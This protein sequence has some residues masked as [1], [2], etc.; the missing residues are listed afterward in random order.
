LTYEQAQAYIASL[1][2]RGWRLGLDRMQAFADRIGLQDALGAPGG[3]QFIHVA[4]TNG[5]GSVTAY[6]QSILVE[7]GYRTGAFFS[8]FVFDPRERVQLGREMISRDDLAALTE[9]LQPV[10]ESFS[11]TA[12]GGIT[13]FEFKT[14]LGFLYWKRKQCEWVALEVGLGGRLDATNV[15]TP[16][17]S[18]IVSIG[19]DH[20]SILG[21]TL[22]EIAYEKAG[23]IKPG[24]PVV[25]GKM[26]GEA[27]HVIE[28]VAEEQGSPVWAYGRE[29]HWYP[30]NEVHTPAGVHENLQ[31]GIPGEMQ[32]HNLALAV[33]AI[34]AV[35][36]RPDKRALE[37]G[38][39]FAFA[40]GRF[41][42]IE[43]RERRFLLD[44]A[45]NPDA[46]DVLVAGLR[47][48]LR[49]QQ[50]VLITN[51][52]AGHEPQSFYREI[53]ALVRSA[54]VVPID[55]HRALPV[56]DTAQALKT[57][58]PTQAHSSIAEGIDAAVKETADD[59]V[60]LVTG[61]FYL[62]GEVGRA[63]GVTGS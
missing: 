2:P 33:A 61:S 19:L 5:K 38:A 48:V 9:E 7:A 24:V 49:D 27:M 58:A 22:E 1:A 29:V 54:H 34:D 3:P 12:F 11:D 23:V 30:C 36:L 6:L 8:P 16:K 42:T 17:A 32:A 60:I 53:A 56:Q 13:E 37:S 59:D 10:A 21:N 28:R 47:D 41:Q 46:A 39:Q 35:G 43:Y 55:F 52:V 4:G 50:V 14:A 51:M 18:V 44:G 63:L 31:P 62:V 26:P 45:H 57:M 15:V 25:V 20:T 40:P